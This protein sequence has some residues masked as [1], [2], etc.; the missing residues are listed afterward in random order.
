[1][2]YALSPA[3][4]IQ[5]RAINMRH[6]DSVREISFAVAAE[7][8]IPMAAIYGPSKLRYV[9]QARQLVMYLAHKSGISYPVIGRALNRDH[10]TIMHGV[11]AEKIRRGELPGIAQ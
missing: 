11:K 3:D 10:T 1:M 6:R 4:I 8:T 2:T 9:V 7:T 5:C